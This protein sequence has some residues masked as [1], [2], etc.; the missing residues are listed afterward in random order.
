MI[1]PSTVLSYLRLIYTSSTGILL[2][3]RLPLPEHGREFF[4]K[5]GVELGVRV[6]PIDELSGIQI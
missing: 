4:I 6:H 5:L 3:V 2:E 1:L